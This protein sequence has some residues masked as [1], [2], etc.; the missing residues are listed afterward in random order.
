MPRTIWSGAIL[1]GLVTSLNAV[2]RGTPGLRAWA[3]PAGTPVSMRE[4]G[5]GGQDCVLGRQVEGPLRKQLT[6]SLSPMAV[7]LAFATQMVGCVAFRRTSSDA[8]TLFRVAGAA[9]SVGTE[10]VPP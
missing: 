8:V 7:S 1:F 4:S 2:S 10:I 5:R 6:G 3:I 9:L